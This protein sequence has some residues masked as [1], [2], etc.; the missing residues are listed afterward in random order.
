[1]CLRPH[2]L[3]HLVCI[4]AER[5]VGQQLFLPEC[6]CVDYIIWSRSLRQELQ[7]R[8]LKIFISLRIVTEQF[9]HQLVVAVQ[10]VNIVR[11]SSQQTIFPVCGADI[12]PSV[13]SVNDEIDRIDGR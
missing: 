6:L 1:M 13:L 9:F 8:K 11:P 4:H 2:S 3:F 10:R 5:L 7:N 12:L